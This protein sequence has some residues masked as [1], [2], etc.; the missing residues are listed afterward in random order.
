VIAEKILP[1]EAVSTLAER[2]IVKMARTKS[3]ISI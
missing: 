3:K 2:Y 1:A